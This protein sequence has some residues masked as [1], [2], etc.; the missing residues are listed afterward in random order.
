MPVRIDRR[1]HAGADPCFS[2]TAQEIT[3][4]SYYRNKPR[5]YLPNIETGQQEVVG[6]FPA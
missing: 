2:P 6:D 4:L 1:A 5:V 3:Y